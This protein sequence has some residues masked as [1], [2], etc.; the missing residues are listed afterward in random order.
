MSSEAS[1][2]W[3]Q[4]VRVVVLMGAGVVIGLLGVNVFDRL[5]GGF[6]VEVPPLHWLLVGLLVITLF[7][8]LVHELGHVAGGKLAGF[9]F[10]ML[11]VGPFKLIREGMDLRLRLNKALNPGGGL[12]LLLPEDEHVSVRRMALYIAGGPVF[13]LAGGVVLFGVMVALGKAGD[14]APGYAGFFLLV[15]AVM[16]IAIG[17]ITFLPLPSSGFANDG[18][19]LLDLMRGGHRAERKLLMLAVVA[20]SMRGVRPRAWA[21]GRVQRALAMSEQET[22]QQAVMASL[23]GYYHHLDRGDAGTA[24]GHLD[25]ALAYLDQYPKPLRSAVRLEAAFFEARHRHRLEA[26]QAHWE[27]VQT[28]GG[29]IEKHVRARAEAALFWTEERYQEAADAAHRGLEHVHKAL[30]RGGA[31]AEKAWLEAILQDS[32]GK[33]L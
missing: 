18:T 17:V 23:L 4:R 1:D 25:K 27:A 14:A 30:D 32:N 9:R 28:E 8:I 31:I 21:A 33:T 12:A 15:S 29:F 16:S 10:F 3:R 24:G 13:S 19:Q 2:R 20:E 6:D 11:V 22:D 26:A 5:T 7:V